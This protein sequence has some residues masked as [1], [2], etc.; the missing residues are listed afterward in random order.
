[1]NNRVVKMMYVAVELCCILMD[2]NLGLT[3]AEMRCIYACIFTWQFIMLLHTS[4][5]FWLAF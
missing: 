2:M 4:L 1:M 5:N 3:S